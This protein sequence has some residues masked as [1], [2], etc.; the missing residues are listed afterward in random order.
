MVKNRL[1]PNKQGT[2]ID[3]ILEPK[4]KCIRNS[5]YLLLTKIY[6]FEM[7]SAKYLR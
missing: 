1:N 5:K 3:L 2:N 6:H 7:L 4:I